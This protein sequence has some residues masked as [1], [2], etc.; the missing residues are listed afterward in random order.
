MARFGTRGVEFDIVPP[1]LRPIL[2][3]RGITILP[4]HKNMGKACTEA[5]EQWKREGDRTEGVTRLSEIGSRGQRSV[6]RYEDGAR[7]GL[8]DMFTGRTLQGDRERFWGISGEAGSWPTKGAAVDAFRNRHPEYVAHMSDDGEALVVSRLQPRQSR[9]TPREQRR[10]EAYMKR[11]VKMVRD[12]VAKWSEK[13]GLHIVVNNDGTGLPR[14][15]ANAK[16]WYDERT[17]T[18]H[19]VLGNHRSVSDVV[20]SILSE[21]VARKGLRELL[22]SEY[23]QFLGQMYKEADQHIRAEVKRTADAEYGGDVRLGMESYMARLAEDTQ[24]DNA[25]NRTWWTRFSR[26]F[27]DLLHRLGFFKGVGR[28]PGYINDDDLRYILWRSYEHLSQRQGATGE[29]G[30]G[31]KGQENGGREVVATATVV[32]LAAVDPVGLRIAEM[33]A[34][35]PDAIIMARDGDGFELRGRDA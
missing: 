10:Y 6:Q 17:D 4:P 15:R 21:G 35:H 9:M 33:K 29:Q 2:V 7:V 31:S 34:K 12:N 3:E 22:G 32:P 26:A 28:Q 24:F 14:E 18:V 5:Y 25:E 11:E 30:A 1:A 27:S 23:D 19:L 8:Y 13:L 16:S 20:A